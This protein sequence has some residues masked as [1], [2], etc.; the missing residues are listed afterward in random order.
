MGAIRKPHPQQTELDTGPSLQ[1]G[2][3]RALQFENLVHTSKGDWKTI[4]NEDKHILGDMKLPPLPEKTNNRPAS[5]ED[6]KTTAKRFEDVPED[7]ELPSPPDKINNQP[8]S[9]EDWEILATYLKRADLDCDRAISD[10]HLSADEIYD[11]FDADN[12]RII[13]SRDI[14][15]HSILSRSGTRLFL[16]VTQVLEKYGIST[17]FTHRYSMPSD[18]TTST[19]K[20]WEKVEN[21]T[22]V[23]NGLETI[24][25]KTDRPQLIAFGEHHARQKIV[26][27]NKTTVQHFAEEVMPMLAHK[28]YR[29]FVMEYFPF[30]LDQSELEYY[31]KNALDEEHTPTLHALF[32][33]TSPVAK[34]EIGTILSQAQQ[35]WSKGVPIRIHGC[36]LTI[37]EQINHATKTN[38]NEHEAVLRIAQYTT[39][40]VKQ[41]RKEGRKVVTYNGGAHNDINTLWHPYSI[42]D[43]LVK[44]GLGRLDY[45]EIGISDLCNPYSIYD[46][47]VKDMLEP[48]DYV[49]IDLALPDVI[50]R[51]G[52]WA[53][54]SR[55][56]PE[57]GYTLITKSPSSF[58]IVYP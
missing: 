42:Y 38:A 52:P 21:I 13:T 2:Q 49:E 54:Y 26:S 20:A 44:G 58:A 1:E 18:P 37:D 53:A 17:Y 19:I 35:L 9:E 34:R 7:I 8:V 57:T 47:F 16:D 51:G 5:K 36:H 32:T 15:N 40:K 31:F 30:D 6:C 41:I 12:D 22:S 3:Y 24:L 56:I 55:V 23:P 14:R 39:R 25:A 43:R 27:G 46:R 11:R 10:S 29:D 45:A 50:D 28:G 48:S 33:K 4:A